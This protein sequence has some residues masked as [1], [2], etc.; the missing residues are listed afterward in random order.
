MSEF[1][2][3]GE[4]LDLFAAATNWKAYWSTQVVPFLGRRVL[5]VGAGLGATARVLAAH[6]DRWT[7]L[8]PDSRL[9]AR[10]R[11]AIDHGD[12]PSSCEVIQG[13]L[14]DLRPGTEYD[15]VL[16]IDVLEHIEADRDQLERSMR[17]LPNGGHIVVLAP[18]HNFLFSRFDASVGH[19]RRYNKR[20]LR[21]IS[22]PGSRLVRLRYLDAFG[23]ALSFGN[24]VLVGR[25]MPSGANI[26][27]WDKVIVRASRPVDRLLGFT[28]GKSI[29]AV[30]Q[31]R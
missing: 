22:P 6:A 10:L 27:F 26:A 20:M 5:D 23:L 25:S 14:E 24:A 4:E 13:F 16:Y 31:K 8:E 12:L 28:I 7:C 18:A 15:S 21:D 2:Y 19:C 29:V 17:V 1:A 11:H 3:V 9:A 30:W